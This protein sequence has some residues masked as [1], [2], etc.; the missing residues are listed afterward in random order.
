MTKKEE[1]EINKVLNKGQLLINFPVMIVMTGLGYLTFYLK[2]I[3]VISNS[4]MIIGFIIAFVGGWLV[5]SFFI[6]KWRIWA[7]ESVDEKLHPYLKEEAIKAKM[8]WKDGHMFEK[9]EIRSEEQK[10]KIEAI[11]KR[12]EELKGDS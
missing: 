7:F 11:N 10:I 5:W 8:I 6:P 2:E 4:V 3:S 12:I 1:I 9:T